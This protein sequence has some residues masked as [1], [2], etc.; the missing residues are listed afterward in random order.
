MYFPK[1]SYIKNLY[2]T[3]YQNIIYFTKQKNLREQIFIS[4]VTKIIK[5]QGKNC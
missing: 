2:I 4:C 5:Q 1:Q 3:T